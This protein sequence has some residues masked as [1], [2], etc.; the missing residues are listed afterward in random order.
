MASFDPMAGSQ[1]TVDPALKPKGGASPKRRLRLIQQFMNAG[2]D[3]PTAEAE[4]DRYIADYPNMGED[5]TPPPAAQAAAPPAAPAAPV[6]APV[7]KKSHANLGQTWGGARDFESEEDRDNY[8]ARRTLTPAE[9]EE[10]RARGMTEADM[11]QMQMS[12]QDIDMLDSGVYGA[13]QGWVPVYDPLTGRQTFKQRAPDPVY[14]GEPGGGDIPPKM[15]GSEAVT[16]KRRIGA[17]VDNRELSPDLQNPELDRAG[18]SIVRWDGPNGPE[19]V[20]HMNRPDDVGGVSPRR[21]EQLAQYDAVYENRQL[22]RIAA[23]AGVDP[24]EAEAAFE[25]GGMNAVRNLANKSRTSN[26]QDRMKRFQAQIQLGGGRLSPQA[27]QLETLLNG[28][29]PDQRQRAMQ[30]MAPGGVLAA[31]VD[32]AEARGNRGDD[33][34][35]RG[36]EAQMEESRADRELQRQQFEARMAADADAREAARLQA[37][38]N[39]RLQEERLRSDNARGLADIESRLKAAQMEWDTRRETAGADRDDRK[40]QQEAQEAQAIKMQQMAW[41]QANPGLYDIATGRMNTSAANTAL[42]NIARQSDRFQWLPGGGF[43]LRE[44]TAMNDELLRIADQAAQYGVESPLADPGYR[45]QLIEQWGY[46]SGWSGGRGGWM[47]DW[48]QPMPEGL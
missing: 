2:F 27:I 26:Q 45:R 43:G 47:G 36:I 16:G 23:S 33:V 6:A 32:A 7:S 5:Y 14:D 8:Q 29:D 31:E 4:A 24:D 1:V 10:M 9:K 38:Q 15:G 11:V 34:R 40:A 12:Q 20:Y 18:Y 19:Y 41:Q 30:Y 42:K 22:Q 37:D 44:A 21:A 17:R 25:K 28:M 48:W 46:A 3:R 35:L 39:M 13:G